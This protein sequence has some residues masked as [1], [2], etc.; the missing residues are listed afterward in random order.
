M[1]AIFLVPSVAHPSALLSLNHPDIPLHGVTWRAAGGG[2]RGRSS[3]KVASVVN[4]MSTF[5]SSCQD[6]RCLFVHVWVQVRNP[7]RVD[8]SN[9][10]GTDTAELLGTVTVGGPGREG[11]TC[12]HAG[13]HDWSSELQVHVVCDRVADSLHAE[14]PGMFLPC[15]WRRDGTD[16]DFSASPRYRL[17]R[18]DLVISSPPTGQ[19]EGTYQ[20]LA[21]NLLGTVL[22]RK[23][24]L[25]FA[26]EFWGENRLIPVIMKR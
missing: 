22:S 7:Y 14:H 21:T 10:P 25:Q 4:R 6:L 18:G 8:L 3:D 9:A 26:C 17:D 2:H 20:C 1:V 23:A 13:L 11:S 12:V 15:R 19:D 16:V 24:K 5:F